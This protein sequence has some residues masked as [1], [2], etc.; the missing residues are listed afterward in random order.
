[1]GMAE[2][3]S[4]PRQMVSC[5]TAVVKENFLVQQGRGAARSLQG[6]LAPDA[7]Q[8]LLGRKLEGVSSARVCP[9][10]RTLVS[11]SPVKLAKKDGVGYSRLSTFWQDLNPQLLMKMW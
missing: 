3:Q 8:S 4:C 2:L 10:Q 7:T 1:M 5:L 11:R 9:V 6:G